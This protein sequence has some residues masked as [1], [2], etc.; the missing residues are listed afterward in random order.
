LPLLQ[1]AFYRMNIK[2]PYYT[3]KDGW[4]IGILL[5]PV[6]LVA[7]YLIFGKQYFTDGSIFFWA[8]VITALVGLVSWHLQIVVAVRLQ[9]K[10]PLYPQTLKRVVWCLSYYVLITT[11]TVCLMF[12]G[13]GLLPFFAYDINYPHMIWAI[14]IGIMV[15]VV[16]ASFHEGFAF[17]EK[18][19]QVTDEAENLKRENLQTQLESLKTQVSPHFLFN[20]LNALSSLI[21]EDP[22][23]AEKFLDELCKVYRYLLRNN[24]EELATLST[25][26]QFIQ[27][28]YHMLKTRFGD[29]LLLQTRISNQFLHYQLPSLTLQM[30]VENAV[31]HNVIKKEQP[32]HIVISTN[33]NGDLVVTNNLQRKI[34]KV[35]S[36][37]IGLNNIVR[38]YQLLKQDA[39]TVKE[40]DGQFQ[41][42]IPLIKVG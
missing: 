40:G 24:E 15:D 25:E 22:E 26:L 21:S 12:G 29:S 33:D 30:L 23:K 20:S 34:R 7:N 36:N 38:K 35:S 8:T 14:G 28:Y 2:L 9:K 19:K 32:L 6:V 4:I 13:Y 17:Y 18:W 11:V 16:A 37:K 27:S 3:K 10:Y 5:P 39:I 41:V 1:A 31:K 42:V